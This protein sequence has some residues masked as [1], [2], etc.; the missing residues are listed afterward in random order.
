MYKLPM[1]IKS[2]SL[3]TKIIPLKWKIG[4]FTVIILLVTVLLVGYVALSELEK[5]YT[6]Q[7]LSDAK[8]SFIRSEFAIADAVRRLEEDTLF[9]TASELVSAKLTRAW[10]A[11]AFDVAVRV[12]TGLSQARSRFC[13]V[14]DGYYWRMVF[15]N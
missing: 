6:D 15:Q 14:L 9:V 7:V 12:A 3:P 13:A 4:L 10:D 1:L 5:S 11:G 8:E 2:G